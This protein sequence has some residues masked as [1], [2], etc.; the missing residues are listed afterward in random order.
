MRHDSYRAS[1]V[2]LD[3]GLDMAVIVRARPASTGAQVPSPIEDLF[4]KFHSSTCPAPD[5]G[6][7]S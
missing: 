3:R 6:R 2:C 4:L 1:Q 5:R 7:N